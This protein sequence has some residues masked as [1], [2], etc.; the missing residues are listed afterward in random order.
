MLR[1]NI[2]KKLPGITIE[3]SFNFD[4]GI[5]VIFGPSGSGKTTIL[6]CIAGL[7]QPDEGHISLDE[8]VFY[9]SV[10]HICIPARGRRI[11][12]VFQDYALFPHLTVKDNIMYGIPSRCKKGKNYRIGTI[13]VLEMLKITHLQHRYPSQLSGGERQRTALARALMVEPDLL[14]LDEPLSA[15]DHGNR[16]AL[17]S[18]L[19]D[20]Q[21]IWRIPF[22]LVTH[23]RKE[24]YA[25]ADEIIFLDKGQKRTHV[26]PDMRR[27]GLNLANPDEY[28]PTHI[29]S[30]NTA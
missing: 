30:G 21:R 11:G 5:L 3:V 28:T 27:S 15:L 9:S 12:Y 8:R 20:L 25:L 14:L 24:M 23:S 10:D 7:R 29:V 2:S 16:R 18:E 22:V 26:Y 19:R 17:Q 1:A 4:R 13:D 6:N